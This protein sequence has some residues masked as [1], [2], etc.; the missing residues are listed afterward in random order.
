MRANL[1]ADAS[2]PEES[3]Q[4]PC[5]AEIPAFDNVMSLL[6]EAQQSLHADPALACEYVGRAL[7]LL[8]QD[9]HST[10][11]SP[12]CLLRWQAD[13]VA[14][15]I[16]THLDTPIRTAQLAAL[17]GL[18]TSHFSHCFKN[19]FGSTPLLYIARCRI[20]SARRIMLTTNTSLTD[21]AL[22]HGFCDQSH[23]IRAFRRQLGVTPQAW[24]RLREAEH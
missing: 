13:R 17:V 24:R 18:S 5:S 20:A 21:I 23:F 1:H 7:T 9:E 2:T 6:R 19:T 12:G 11:T 4:V 10:K 22:S 14:D 8:Q 3:G 15:Y 16:N